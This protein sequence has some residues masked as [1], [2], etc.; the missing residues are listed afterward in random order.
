MKSLIFISASSAALIGVG[1]WNVIDLPMPI[2]TSIRNELEEK[3]DETTYNGKYAEDYLDYFVGTKIESNRKWWTWRFNKKYLPGAKAATG[4][5]KSTF[6]W[7]GQ[8]LGQACQKAY[9][10][11]KGEKIK[12]DAESLSNDQFRESDVWKYCSAEPKGR[13]VKNIKEAANTS[14]KSTE[15]QENNTYGKSEN[16]DKFIYADSADN[17]WFWKI[18]TRLFYKKGVEMWGEDRNKNSTSEFRKLYMSNI[19][20]KILY[21]E[22]LKNRCKEAYGK[23]ESEDAASYP[24]EEVFKFCSIKGSE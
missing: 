12:G 20:Q 14:G 21:K 8:T 2:W 11:N 16:K 1:V 15:G 22:D 4:G 23:N 9:E 17:D 6:V 13:K 5:F 18:K 24:K 7:N 3:E 19:S 10:A